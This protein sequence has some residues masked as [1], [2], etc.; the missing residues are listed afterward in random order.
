MFKKVYILVFAVIF[1]L[2]PFISHAAEAPKSMT[3]YKQSFDGLYLSYQFHDENGEIVRF[4]YLV[5]DSKLQQV[6]DSTDPTLEAKKVI[7]AA[8]EIF[9]VTDRLKE[10]NNEYFSVYDITP[11]IDTNLKIRFENEKKKQVLSHNK[12]S[13]RGI[14]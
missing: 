10:V 3:L 7:T 13:K 12:K 8:Y 1:S 5:P 2:I 14:H 6:R 9:S 11:S 4:S